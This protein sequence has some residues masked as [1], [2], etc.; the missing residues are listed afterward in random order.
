MIAII[1]LGSN[2]GDR[3]AELRAAVAAMA[4]AGMRVAQVSRLLE[5][6]PQG[7]TGR[8]WFVN[9]VAQV[10]TDLLPRVLLR[11]LRAIELRQGRGRA[12]WPGKNTPRRLDLDLLFYGRARI[13]TPELEVPHP[14]W[15]EREF[16]LQGLRELSALPG[17][18]GAPGGRGS[19]AWRPA[20]AG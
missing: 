16:V 15:R 11:R 5:T 7:A 20:A 6:R 18:R 2:R 4:R 3:A 17:G 13:H 10:E 1:A 19:Q 9:A 12:G 8:R 14:R